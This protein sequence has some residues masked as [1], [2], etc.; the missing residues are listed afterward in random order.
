MKKFLVV[1]TT[2]A[3]GLAFGL[4]QAEE[5]KEK[6]KG[7]KGGDMA[8]RAEA[9][10]KQ[11]DKDDSKTLSEEEFAAGPMA[12]K[13]K[14]KGGDEAVGKIFKARDTNKD[15]QLDLAELSAAPKGKGDGKGKK[16]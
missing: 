3:A 1:V 13:A 14:E 4:V 12:A 9:M 8:A 15:G 16:P 2:V 11:L 6:G 10:L 5:G 7:E